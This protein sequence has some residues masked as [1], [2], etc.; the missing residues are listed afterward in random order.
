[1]GTSKASRKGR[2][3][4]TPDHPGLGVVGIVPKVGDP[5]SR[6]SGP[7]EPIPM[8]F[9][10]LAKGRKKAITRARVSSGVVVG[11]RRVASR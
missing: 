6:S 3:R 9:S 1:M 7:K 8:A 2:R 5:G 10:V 11:M 4:F